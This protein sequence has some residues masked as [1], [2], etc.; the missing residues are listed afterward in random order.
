M[1][2][3]LPIALIF[4][5]LPR[6]DVANVSFFLLNWNT[7]HL[8]KSLYAIN[9]AVFVL[10]REQCAILKF[11]SVNIL[12]PL[13]VPN[14]STSRFIEL[15]ETY[16]NGDGKKTGLFPGLL[17]YCYTIKKYKKL[18][19]VSFAGRVVKKY[20]KLLDIIIIAKLS[21]IVFLSQI[22]PRAQSSADFD[23]TRRYNSK[24]QITNMNFLPR[25]CVIFSQNISL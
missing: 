2:K 23:N 19:L 13:H 10:I 15:R 9:C 22:L 7:K 12:H 4:T 25:E 11:E 8:F 17:C 14:R 1:C 18:N 5:I 24:I 21:K 3:T 6:K 16:S 20:A